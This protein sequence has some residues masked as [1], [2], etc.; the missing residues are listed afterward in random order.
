M[1]ELLGNLQHRL[2]GTTSSLLLSVYKILFGAF[3]GLTLALIGSQVIGYGDFSF[4]LVIVGTTLLFQKISRN[5]KASTV[6]VFSLVCVLLGLLLR[7]YILVA[8]GA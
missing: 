2:K 6:L 5:W 4:T 3:L 8:P 1:S 7:M